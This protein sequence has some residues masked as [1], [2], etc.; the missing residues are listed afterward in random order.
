MPNVVNLTLA[1]F[2]SELGNLERTLSNPPLA[3]ALERVLPN[4]REGIA[5]NFAQSRSPDGIPWAPRKSG[6]DWPLLIKT[7]EMMRSVTTDGGNGFTDISPESLTIGSHVEYYGF[8]E[9]G[10][11]RMP[12]RPSLGLSE[13]ALDKVGE[14]L[15]DAILDELGV[16]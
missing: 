7:G 3:E 8:H 6:G 14:V 12:A 11:S 4:V 16:L 15:A 13:D 1:G 2:A 5:D 10:T 9:D